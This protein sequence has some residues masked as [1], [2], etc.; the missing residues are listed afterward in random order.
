MEKDFILTSTE[1]A[2]IIGISTE[3]LRSKRRRGLYTD[4]YV[5]KNKSYLWKKPR[6]IK[7]A[8]PHVRDASRLSA[9]ASNTNNITAS[10]SL[11]RHSRRNK[12][13]GNHHKELRS[14]A[15]GSLTKYPNAAFKLA[16]EFK[17]VAKAQRKISA[18]AAE[19]ITEDVIRIAEQK[20]REKLLA[21]IKPIKI[22]NYTSGIYDCRN[23]II[24]NNKK[25]T[26]KIEYW[27]RY[28]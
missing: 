17:M 14:S 12:N 1:F 19:E 25:S 8:G 22:K 3:S 26:D 20:H 7:V 16:N 27:K 24:K 23:E 13:S 15:N 10:H 4:Q 6:P 21:A 2:R 9:H 5:L 18:A 11:I 28:Y